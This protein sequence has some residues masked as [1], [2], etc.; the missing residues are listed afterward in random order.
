M[1]NWSEWHRFSTLED[2]PARDAKHGVYQIRASDGEGRPKSIPRACATGDEGILYIGQGAIVGRLGRL[3]RSAEECPKPHHQFI[4][5]VLNYGL[6][7][8]Y[9]PVGFEVRWAECDDCRAVETKLLNDYKRRTG[10]IPPGN[11]SLA[12]D[13]LRAEADLTKP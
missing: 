5:V 2:H 3:L 1:L 6:N 8:N 9:D 11:L 7:R 10:D 12:G 13:G 4:G